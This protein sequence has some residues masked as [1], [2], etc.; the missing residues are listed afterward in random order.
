MAAC[1]EFVFE[2]QRSGSI[3]AKHDCVHFE[4]FRYFKMSLSKKGNIVHVLKL[5]LGQICHRFVEEKVGEVFYR[6]Q[7]A[8]L[9]SCGT[10]E[11]LSNF[12]LQVTDASR[13][14]RRSS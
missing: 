5:P 14:C 4:R 1:T 13:S 10:P 11:T 3:N 7:D 9:Q 8:G 2:E 12:R 6:T